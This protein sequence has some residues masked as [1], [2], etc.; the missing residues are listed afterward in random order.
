MMASFAVLVGNIRK[1]FI[2]AFKYLRPGQLA[3]D[4]Y[5]LLLLFCSELLHLLKLVCSG[6]TSCG[7]FAYNGICAVG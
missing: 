6:L 4:H 7:F 5:E 1:T 3:Y 2:P